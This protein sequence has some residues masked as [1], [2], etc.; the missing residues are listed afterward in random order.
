MD[1]KYLRIIDANANRAVEGLRVIEEILRL[2]MEDEKNTRKI[3]QIRSKIRQSI[4]QLGLLEREAGKDVGSRSYTRSESSRIDLLAVFSANVKRV[5]EALRV[6]EEF[7]KLIDEKQG[8]VFK[9]L[10]FE[11]YCLE[12]DIFYN[13]VKKL[14]LDFD[15]YL[16]TDPQFDPLNTVKK[17]LKKGVK[18][19][20]FRD[21]YA[22][23]EQFL[24][25]AKDLK[26]ITDKHK[27]V[28]IVNDHLDIAKTIDAD[29]VH[30]GQEDGS[31]I[32]A[33][34]ILGLSK[35]I[36]R[37]VQT[38]AQAIQAQKQGADYLGVG[39]IFKTPIKPNEK[40]VGLKILKQIVKKVK[41]PVV[42]IG[43]ID[44]SNLSKI[45]KTSC[46]RYATIRGVFSLLR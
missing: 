44:R 7:S 16:V 33:R 27:A 3:K 12:K 18:I 29:G 45:L 2:I 22:K 25:M 30:L 32:K 17:A 40:V 13:I 24:R 1:K 15:L 14:K 31:I 39:P 42:A 21:K 37:S 43:G 41:L 20:Q 19:V 26:K 36:G 9:A 28:F 38:L 4:K 10:R 6:L 11:S 34:K 35:I 8:K 5:Q 46:I 23:K